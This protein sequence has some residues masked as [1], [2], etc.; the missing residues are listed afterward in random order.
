MA[1]RGDLGNTEAMGVELMDRFM[2][3]VQVAGVLM[4][5]A[6]VGAIAL[7]RRRLPPTEES[8]GSLPPGE[9]GKRVK[10]F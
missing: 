5:V 3:A 9:V 7:A 1:R 6:M 4:L 10:P 8:K 2:V